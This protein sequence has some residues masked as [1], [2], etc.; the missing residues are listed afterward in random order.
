MPFTGEERFTVIDSPL[1]EFWAYALS[2]L[3]ENAARGLLAE[4][5][6]AKAVQATGL[7]VEWDAYDVEAPDGTTIE[8]KASGH[9]Q[10]W[11]RVGPPVISFAG[12]PGK[13]GKKSWHAQ[14]NTWTDVHI[15][16]VYVF[17]VHTTPEGE[18]YNG[19]DVAAWDFYVLPGSTVVAT[20]QQSMRLSTVERLGAVRV[21]WSG[22]RDAIEVAGWRWR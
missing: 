21:S 10:T 9:S 4:Y 19:L 18:P 15:A 7:R 6:V 22:L 3:Q 1:R 11:A 13:A 5:L 12:L 2:N 17:A 16:D 8:V 20:G 14:S